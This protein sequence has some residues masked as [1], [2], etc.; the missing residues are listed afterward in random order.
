MKIDLIYLYIARDPN[1]DQ[2][3]E[4]FARTYTEFPAGIDH[5][6]NV[7][8]CNGE[9]RENL[10]AL[11]DPLKAIYHEY[12]GNGRDIGAHQSLAVK[13]D[14]DWVVCT[15]SRTY[16]HREGWLNRMVEAH[17][18][19]GNGLFGAMASFEGRAHIRTCFYACNP[20]DFKE[21]PFLIDSPPDSYRFESGFGSFTD[22]FAFKE[23]PAVMV[24]WNG[25]YPKRYWRTG[26]NIF[27][28]GD[29]SNCLVFD[30]HTDEYRDA[31]QK[32]RIYYQ[33]L[34]DGLVKP[35]ERISSKQTAG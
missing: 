22:W 28:K 27:R 21:Y 7:I 35:D 8:V 31:E 34:A 1:F 19:Y 25:E 2:F 9:P 26:N 5:Q 32:D 17:E 29:Q 20:K 3:A 10:H 23:K 6:L 11:F 18:Q 13:L 4:R 14:S 33:R 16:F 24:T 30:R 12:S 15:S